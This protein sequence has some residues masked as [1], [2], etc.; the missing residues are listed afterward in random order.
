M[1]ERIIPIS[2]YAKADNMID[3]KGY[4]SIDGI[5]EKIE[6]PDKK[7]LILYNFSLANGDIVVP[8]N[9]D[10]LRIFLKPTIAKG[11]SPNDFSHFLL[12]GESVEKVLK[13]KLQVWCKNTRWCSNQLSAN[14]S[15]A[16]GRKEVYFDIPMSEVKEEITIVGLSLIHI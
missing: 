8:R 9:H 11:H 12:N 6:I 13:L 16:T 2:P 7:H 10:I 15:D 5:E 3:L 1:S 4:V 14:I